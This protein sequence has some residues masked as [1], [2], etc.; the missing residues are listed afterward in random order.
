MKTQNENDEL[1]SSPEVKISGNNDNITTDENVQGITQP[2]EEN[3]DTDDWFNE[4]AI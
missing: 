4:S 1:I 3:Y 2:T